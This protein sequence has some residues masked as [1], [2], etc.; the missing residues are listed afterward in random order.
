MEAAAAD[1]PPAAFVISRQLDQE[2]IQG[3]IL[4]VQELVKSNNALRLSSGQNEKDTHDIVLYF[5]REMEIKDDV[6]LRLNEEL[7]KSQTQLKNEVEKVRKGFEVDLQQMKETSESTIS[8]LTVKLSAAEA[9]LKSVERFLQEKHLHDSQVKQLEKTILDQRKQFIDAMEDQERRFLEEKS[10]LFKD[11]DEQKSAFREVALKEARSAMG[12]EAKKI[13][14]DNNRM[15]EE[16]KFHHAESSENQAD[17][18]K[19]MFELKTARREVA[20]L[21]EKE[22][23]YAKQAYNR[24]K[25]IKTLRDKVDQLEKQQ[26]VNSERFKVRAKELKSTV[27]RELEEAMLDCAGLR[28]LIQIKNKELKQMKSLAATI[29]SQRSETEQFFLESLQEVREVIKTERQLK[30]SQLQSKL[31]MNKLKNGG[32]SANTTFPPLNIKGNNLHMI[33]GKYNSE[34]QA[35]KTDEKVALKDL[36]WE[37]K[38]LVLR[39]LFSKMNSSDSNK[40]KAGMEA[41]QQLDLGQGDDPPVFISQGAGLQEQNGDGTAQ[42]PHDFN[43][44]EGTVSLSEMF[45]MKTKLSSVD[46]QSYQN[47]EG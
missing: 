25:E 15:F 12:E 47:I 17:K 40:L 31:L 36:T 10:H 11:L 23:E 6:I 44:S 5:Q 9:D 41:L 37:D 38:E 33:T 7:V 2:R 8:H 14:A 30:Q 32:G 13:L 45:D 46:S 28:R 26:A 34:L 24:G 22:I 19:L 18:N 16:L 39:V 3:L 43:A 42:V 4:R 21:A 1:K 27:S 35:A 20:I 29:L